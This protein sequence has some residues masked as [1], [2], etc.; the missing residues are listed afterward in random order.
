M[1]ATPYIVI[2]ISGMW[3]VFHLGQRVRT[4]AT[5]EIARIYCRAWNENR[6]PR[7]GE[8]AAALSKRM[9]AQV[10]ERRAA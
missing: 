5:E 4:F 10:A 1:S 3:E 9:V 7:G 2:K 8:I 6:Q